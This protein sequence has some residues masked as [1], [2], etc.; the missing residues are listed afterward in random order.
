MEEQE[1]KEH[2]AVAKALLHQ[3]HA[4][5]EELVQKLSDPQ[6]MQGTGEEVMQQMWECIANLSS[7]LTYVEVAV[8]SVVDPEWYRE[9]RDKWLAAAA[10]EGSS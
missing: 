4:M 2:E 1:E 5:R 7:R 8:G 3:A 6:A 9:N 10:S